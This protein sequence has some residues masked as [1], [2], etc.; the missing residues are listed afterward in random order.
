MLLT[1]GQPCRYCCRASSI[2]TK[3]HPSIAKLHVW[4]ERD[5][6]FAEHSCKCMQPTRAWK[7]NKL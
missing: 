5:K 3:S 4:I 1:R 2:C 7:T 6:N